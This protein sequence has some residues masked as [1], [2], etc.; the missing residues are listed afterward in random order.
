MNITLSADQDLIEKSR[1]YARAHG[2]SLN[3]LVRDY[4]QRLTGELDTEKS[5]AEFVALALSMPGH[6]KPG[7]KFSRDELYDRFANK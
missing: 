2:T 3:Q 5:A 4:L 6:S 1:E 7:Y